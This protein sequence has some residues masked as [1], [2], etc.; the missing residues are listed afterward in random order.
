VLFVPAKV[1]P[2][3]VPPTATLYGVEAKPLTPMPCVAFDSFASQL[4]APSSPAETKMDTP[5]VTPWWYT[6]LKAALAAEPL[7]ASHSP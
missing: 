2:K 1:S 6:E 4:A 5:S 3:S 7:I